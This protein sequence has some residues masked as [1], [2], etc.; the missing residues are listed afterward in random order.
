MTKKIIFPAILMTLALSACS[1]TP[2]NPNAPTVLEQ[3]KN[4]SAAPN[5]KHN[6]A[7]LIRQTDNCV[8]EFTGN[9]ETGKAT[10]HWIFKGE[11]LISAF[12]NVDADIEQKQTVFDPKDAEKLKNF[13]SLKN[14]FKVSNL[15]KCN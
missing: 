2:S 6:L 4:I 3:H 12:S 10:E 11:Q 14:N 1:T 5:T 8:I 13:N 15:E 9:F 7:R